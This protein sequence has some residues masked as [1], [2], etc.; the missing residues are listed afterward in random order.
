MSCALFLTVAVVTF[1][2]QQKVNLELCENVVENRVADRVQWIT[3]RNL[4]LPT[5][6][7]SEQKQSLDVLIEGVLRPIPNLECVDNKPVPK[8]G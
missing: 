1:Y 6:E 4:I 5:L 8:E 3:F 2:H 7:T